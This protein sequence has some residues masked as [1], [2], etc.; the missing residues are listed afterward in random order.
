MPP[1]P[2]KEQIIILS[3]HKIQN[4]MAYLSEEIKPSSG[5]T[6][7]SAYIAPIPGA[8]SGSPHNQPDRYTRFYPGRSIAPLSSVSNWNGSASCTESSS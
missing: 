7:R 4:V 2:G 6:G 1:K 3:V 5:R 8:G